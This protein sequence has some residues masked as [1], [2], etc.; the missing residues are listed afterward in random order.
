MSQF[1]DK[2]KHFLK[3]HLH[4]VLFAYFWLGLFVCGLLAPEARV[5]E[6]GSSVITKGWHLS[7]MS[8]VL[9]LPVPIIYYFRMR[10][11]ED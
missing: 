1:S 3:Y 4:I 7:L 8:L 11:S 6:L 9:I 5:L 2:I 10:G